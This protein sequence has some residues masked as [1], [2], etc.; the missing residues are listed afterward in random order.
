[1]T[2]YEKFLTDELKEW[3]REEGFINSQC[4]MSIYYKYAPDGGKDCLILC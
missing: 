3:L 1:M 2:N 4:Q